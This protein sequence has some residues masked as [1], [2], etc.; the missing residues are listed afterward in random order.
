MDQYHN[1]FLCGVYC[2][3]YFTNMSLTCSVRFSGLYVH[4]SRLLYGIHYKLFH[5]GEKA[6]HIM[7][8]E[9]KEFG[10]SATKKYR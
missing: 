7:L 10:E 2:S 9:A 4:V 5:S 1:R 3:T 8:S 6:F